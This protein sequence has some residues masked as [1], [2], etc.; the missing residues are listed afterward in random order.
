VNANTVDAQ[1]SGFETL[2]SAM[3][4]LQKRLNVK[5]HIIHVI[6][7]PVLKIALVMEI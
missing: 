5:A 4:T 2:P 7:V 6:I 3:Q 1:I